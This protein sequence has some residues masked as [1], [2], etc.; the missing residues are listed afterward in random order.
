[1]TDEIQIFG[2]RAWYTE[3]RVFVSREIAWADL[4]DD[5]FLALTLYYNV[6]APDGYP[7]ARTLSGSDW[8][9]KQGDIYGSSMDGGDKADTEAEIE[10]RYP[11]ASVK[12]GK[13]TT[14]AEMHGV[15][16][17]QGKARRL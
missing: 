17:Q 6:A 16:A 10:E 15:V 4:P 12:R 1:M 13:W 8:Y 9:F 2:W 3:G 7:L 14:D 11:G 5:G